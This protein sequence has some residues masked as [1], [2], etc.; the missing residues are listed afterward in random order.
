MSSPVAGGFK[1]PD[2]DRLLA[3]SLRLRAF[4]GMTSA[5]G[6][7]PSPRI[8]ATVS[9]QDKF[10]TLC[11]ETRL[12]LRVPIDE[13][14]LTAEPSNDRE[15]VRYMRQPNFCQTW[16]YRDLVESYAERPGVDPR[17]LLTVRRTVVDA[18][19]LGIPLF[20]QAFGPP[21]EVH[22]GHCVFRFLPFLCWDFVAGLIEEAGKATGY[23][24]EPADTVPGQFRLSPDAP[25]LPERLESTAPRKLT[26]EEA[27]AER[28]VLLH[29]Y[30]GGVLGSAPHEDGEGPTGAR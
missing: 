1:A 21:D 30:S 12:V 23:C 7:G 3:F 5:D 24:L 28:E 14:P 4:V 18:R 19:K 11:D 2:L 15:A 20:A 29:H 26:R 22:L 16:Q 25:E 10:R 8:H 13:P 17:L 27:R 6:R 9:A